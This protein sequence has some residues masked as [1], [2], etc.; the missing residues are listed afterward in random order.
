ME[1]AN[2]GAASA[3]EVLGEF[4]ARLSPAL[5]DR[6][7]LDVGFLDEASPGVSCRAAQEL[8]RS[9][10][11]P[12][13]GAPCNGLHMWKE[14]K[15]L[16]EEAFVAALAATL[17]YCAA[18]G[19]DFLFAGPLRHVRDVA[20]GLAAAGVYNRYALV[21]ETG[22]RDFSGEHPMRALFGALG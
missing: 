17:G 18:F 13:G 11:L 19:L 6:L 10:G 16:G 5:H 15:T 8:R 12:V 2:F 7:L 1:P 14:L 3:L 20:P 21:S 4:K 22:R 9:A